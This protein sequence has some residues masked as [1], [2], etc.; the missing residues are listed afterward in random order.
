MK[1][2][3]RSP[4]ALKMS[5]RDGIGSPDF[6]S[7]SF[8]MS[9]N[10]VSSTIPVPVVVR[11]RLSSCMMTSLESFEKRMSV[12]N[13][14]TPFAMHFANPPAALSSYSALPPR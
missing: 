5:C 11:S 10:V 6:F 7:F 8:R 2:S 4:S 1:M 13:P 14:R 12:S 9:S 3:S